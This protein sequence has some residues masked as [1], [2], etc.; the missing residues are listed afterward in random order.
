M[1]LLAALERVPLDVL[2]GDVP[3]EGDLAEL[4]SKGEEFDIRSDALG[5]DPQLLNAEIMERVGDDLEP[6]SLAGAI[7]LEIMQGGAGN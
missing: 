5:C 4:L 6:N 1:Q 2:T 7:L 3:P